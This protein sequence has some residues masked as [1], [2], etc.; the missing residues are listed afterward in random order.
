MFKKIHLSIFLIVSV[1]V[2]LLLALPSPALAAT[3]TVDIRVA[4]GDDDA[5]ERVQNGQMN[6]GSSD[7]ELIREA[8]DQTVGIRFNNVS[9]P[10]GATITNAFIEFT[11][12]EKDSET[13]HLVIEGEANDNASRFEDQNWN[14]SD[15][16]RTSA[17]VTWDNVPAWGSI[18]ETGVKQ[19]TPDLK[20]IV[21]EIVDRPGWSGGSMVFLIKGSG[22]RVAESYNGKQSKAALLHVEYTANELVIPVSSS[23]DDAME[24]RCSNHC[25]NGQNAD[26]VRLEQSYLKLPE[27]RDE[28]IGLRFQN[29]AI[30][31]GTIIN[32]AYLEFVAA[33]YDSGYTEWV[34]KGQAA[35]DPPAFADTNDN[36]S[37]RPRT[38]QGVTWAVPEIW[39]DGETRHSPDISSIIQEI[40][41]R[42]GWVEGNSLVLT[43]GSPQDRRDR[44]VYSYDGG[45]PPKLHI[46]FGNE[47]G[48]DVDTDGDGILDSVDNCPLDFNDD[49][50]DADNNGVGDVCDYGLPDS[51]GD[52]IDDLIDN[53][54]DVP[55]PGQQDTDGDGIGD[56]CDTAPY[57]TLNKENIGTSC[58]EGENAN[59]AVFKITNS[60][61][62]TSNYTVSVS[63][64]V[65]TGW[66]SLNPTAGS[67]T[68]GAGESEDYTISFNSASLTQG[69]YNA[70]ISI[71]DPNAPNSPEEIIVSLTVFTLPDEDVVSATCGHVPVYVDNMVSPAMLVL[72]DVSGSMDNMVDVTEED[73]PQTP[74][75]K[76][77]VQEIVDRPG[78]QSDPDA[79]YSM[80]FIIEGSGD[81]D[82]KT[83]DN[84]TSEAPL[85]HVVYTD[86]TGRH[87]TDIRVNQ[88]SDDAEEDSGG[89]I[90]LTGNILDMMESGG[91]RGIGVRFRNVTIP[92]GATIDSAYIEFAVANS[93]SSST[94]L[95]IYGQ[96]YDNPPTFSTSSGDV[97]SRIKTTA[98][99]SW[100]PPAWGG[101]TQ[102][103][104]ITI[105]KDVISELVKDRSISWGFGS[106]T[107]D[108]NGTDPDTEFDAPAL[109]YT[110][111]HAGTKPNTDAHQANLQR[112]ISEQVPIIE[113]PFIESILAAKKYFQSNKKEWI[114]DRD[115]NGDIVDQSD[116]PILYTDSGELKRYSNKVA[117]GTESG[118]AY[119]PYTCQPKFLINITDGRGGS[120]ANQLVSP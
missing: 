116:N 10:Q 81:R 77:I 50:A 17:S 119:V 98:S 55:N 44:D 63:Y 59:N 87:T 29:V 86:G 111:I 72:L 91:N 96:D 49:Q 37:D 97:S 47:T 115:S 6:L 56:A 113:T 33:D 52:S 20:T 66:L 103:M 70:T 41:G 101:T 60:G 11:T 85:L 62:A 2:G 4:H 22:K 32:N 43:I 25:D 9:V 93:T 34:I 114:Y 69:V 15:R 106:W 39:Q 76:S 1:V 23:D 45:Y 42:P 38:G 51:D 35:D 57:L 24:K 74:D 54:V 14:I 100:N 84:S 19:Q 107:W 7:L 99:V 40:V 53:C 18:G 105:G 104:R 120:P 26:Y 67:N 5:E 61:A 79:E 112:A 31:K 58:Y 21:Q 82:A 30:P 65:G 48:G 92:Q 16:T 75:I 102:Q 27:D 110:L 90:L 64:S 108:N 80:V 68:L 71:T 46:Q 3:G 95:T 8:D 83:Y 12:D 88:S 118:D 117:K 94:A 109:D 78:W 73:S 13:T 89:G 28:P 36:I